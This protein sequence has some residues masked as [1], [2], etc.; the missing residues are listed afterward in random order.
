MKTFYIFFLVVMLSFAAFSQGF[1]NSENELH[2]PKNYMNYSTVPMKDAFAAPTWVNVN[3][4]GNEAPQNEPSVRI[5]RANPDIVVAAWRDFRLGYTGNNIIRR[6]GYTYSSDGGT[7]WA[8]SQLLPDPNPDH[9]SQSDPVV[10]SDMEGNF[11][12]SSTSRQPVNGYNREMLL[13]KSIDNGQTFLLHDIAVPG[14]GGAGEDKEWLFCDPVPENPTY[15]Q[16]MMVWRSFGPAYGIR[17][18]KSEVGGGDWSATRVVSDVSSGQGANIT[19][20]VNGEI[21]VVWKL[22]GIWM[23]RSLDG[24]ETFGEDI[25]ISSYPWDTY[26]SFPFL[27]TDYSDKGTRGNI[28]LVWADNRQDDDDVWFQRS[29][30]G[31]QSWLDYPVRVNDVSTYDQFWPVIQ[32]DTNGRVYVIYYDDRDFPGLYNTWLA[33]SDDAGDTWTNARLSEQS[34]YFNMPNTDVRFGDYIQVDAYAGKVIPV[35]TDDRTGDYNQ[36]IYSAWV[37]ISTFISEWQD[38]EAA[39]IY[40]SYPN[41]FSGTTTI[42]FTLKDEGYTRLDILNAMGQ[43]VETLHEGVLAVG[44]H[45]FQWTNEGSPGIY[46]YLLTTNRSR[47][48][49]RIISI[50]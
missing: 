41:P 35:W 29:T 4:S 40:P 45:R 34:F 1:Y 25:E 33:W 23:D 30:D 47:L 9:I 36:E 18:R 22:D 11:Y 12:I 24:G 43:V 28:Y 13:Y 38:G 44:D 21:V 3:L 8:P 17:F 39:T 31:G 46:H 15:N 6:I 20:G 42:S 32:C 14:S 5:S 10:T 26:G 27:C 7:T 49:G 48:S 50:E 19:T 2:A 16:L 37:D